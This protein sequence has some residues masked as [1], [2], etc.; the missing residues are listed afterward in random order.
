MYRIVY[1][2]TS[3]TVRVGRGWA[4]FDTLKAAQRWYKEQPILHEKKGYVFYRPTRSR[5]CYR[6]CPEVKKYLLEIIEDLDA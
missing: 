6:N 1:L 5:H 3:E 2:P 4:I